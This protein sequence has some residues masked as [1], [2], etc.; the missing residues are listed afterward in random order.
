MH[1][2]GL[3]NIEVTD[4]ELHIKEKLYAIDVFRI[5]ENKYKDAEI[6]FIM[7]ADNFANITKWKN[8]DELLKMYKYIILDRE[9]IDL[10]KFITKELEKNTCVIKNEEYNICSSSS[11]RD[12]LKKEK[13][14]NKEIISDEVIDYI[15]AN[16]LYKF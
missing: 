3:K 11:F 7:G 15:I 2:N 10:N 8:S 4:F 1:A 16:N 14:Y 12:A 13:K 9:N 6:F 5:I